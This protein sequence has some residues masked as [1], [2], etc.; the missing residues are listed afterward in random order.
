[1]P[2]SKSS[3][4]PDFIGI[5]ARRCASSRMHQM[6]NAHPDVVK[7]ERGTHF[8][9]ENQGAEV[10]EYLETFPVPTSNIVRVDLSVSYLYPEFAPNVASAIAEFRPEAQLFATIRDPV[11]R[12][13]SDY[14]RSIMLDEI[15]A[16]MD[17]ISACEA[18]PEFVER[19]RYLTL[20][21]PYWN[22]FGRE[23]VKLF[24]YESLRNDKNAFYHEL[25]EYLG[26]TATPFLAPVKGETGHAHAVR[27]PALQKILLS[28]KGAMRT[29]ARITGLN[30][31]WTG[32]TRALQPAYQK[33]LRMN[34]REREITNREITYLLDRFGRDTAEFI[35]AANLTEIAKWRQ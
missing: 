18:H 5:G 4:G 35:K 14:L 2:K 22:L 6:L 10:E 20:L 27:S 19:S 11:A 15:D 29:G 13:Y 17:L 9:S 23:G 26:I 33:I 7:P 32:V 31:V 30:P 1:M 28:T 16:S 24:L 21:D 8:F 25:A 3:R 34:G 12:T